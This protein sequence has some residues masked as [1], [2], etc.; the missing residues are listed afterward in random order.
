[1][2]QQDDGIEIRKG[3]GG[4]SAY[5]GRS[6]VRVSDVARMYPLMLDEL[7]IERMSRSLPSLTE[8]QLAEALAYWRAHPEMIQAEI[9]EEEKILASLPS[10][11]IQLA[12]RAS[13]TNA[14]TET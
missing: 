10:V 5:I 7:I 13:Q 3:A 4:E 14:T 1:M 9:D 2:G 8:E 6:R 11:E 12:R